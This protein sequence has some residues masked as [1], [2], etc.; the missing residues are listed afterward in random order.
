MRAGPPSPDRLQHI[1]MRKPTYT[2][3]A[4][5]HHPGICSHTAYG[6]ALQFR[7]QACAKHLAEPAP[8]ER[9]AQDGK[10]LIDVIVGVHPFEHI[11]R[12]NESRRVEVAKYPVVEPPAEVSGRRR[13]HR[14][15][16]SEVL[17]FDEKAEAAIYRRWFGEELFRKIIVDNPARLYA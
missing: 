3:P 2:S 8:R 11:L 4:D 12:V 13:G 1:A 16:S 7:G 14:H 15:G 9:T 5:I 17:V 10:L 6:P